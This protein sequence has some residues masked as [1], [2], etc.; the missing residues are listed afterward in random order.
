MKKTSDRAVTD[1]AITASQT[2]KN[3]GQSAFQ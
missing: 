2:A 1:E 3:G